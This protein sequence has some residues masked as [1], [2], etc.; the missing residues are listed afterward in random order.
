MPSNPRGVAG[1]YIP[2]LDGLRA[3]AVG[4][5][6]AYHMFA[7][8]PLVRHGGKVGVDIFFVISGYIITSILVRELERDGTLSLRS[9]FGKRLVRL[10]PALALVVTL[11]IVPAALTAPRGSEVIW[12]G[13]WALLYLTPVTAG[14]WDIKL[15]YELTWTLGLEEYFYL[16]FPTFLLLVSRLRWTRGQTQSLLVAG[17]VSLLLL[18]TAARYRSADP[19][20][21][22]DYLRVGG[23]GLGCALALRLH[24]RPRL[25]RGIWASAAGG[26]LILAAMWVAGL[27]RVNGACYLL[28]DV[29]ALLLVASFVSSEPG[30]VARTLALRPVAYFGLISYEIYLWHGPVLSI[31]GWVTD[32]SNLAIC[33][34]AYPLAIGLAALTHHAL[35]PLQQTLRVRL[36]ARPTEVVVP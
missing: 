35:L 13:V 21:I 5:V 7:P 32:L 9:F 20:G 19:N 34:W 16:C 18:T 15:G 30:A 2:A 4:L 1:N 10:W 36:H 11:T 6:L 26:L 28:A 23:I 31:G 3:V 22:F 25:R 27:E 33:W 24:D 17:S 8:V 14:L 29:G 12:S